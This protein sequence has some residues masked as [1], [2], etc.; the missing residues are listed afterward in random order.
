MKLQFEL[1]TKE[2]LNHVSSSY[3]TGQAWMIPD[4]YTVNGDIIDY[5]FYYF[6]IP[7]F[8]IEVLFIF[9]LLFLV[10]TFISSIE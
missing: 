10:T 3:S 6:S 1:M 4:L 7:G 5:L 8:N 9:G 2:M